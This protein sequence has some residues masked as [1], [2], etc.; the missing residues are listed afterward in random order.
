MP[1]R[2]AAHSSTSARAAPSLA[3]A[4]R[5]QRRAGGRADSPAR[6]GARAPARRRPARSC[7]CDRPHRVVLGMQRLDD[8]AARP[9][10]PPRRPPTGAGRRARRR[11]SRHAQQ[12]VEGDEADAAEA[13]RRQ[14]AQQRGRADDH[15]GVAASARD[16]E[17]REALPHRGLD[18]LRIPAERREPMA[19]ARRAAIGQGVGARAEPAAEARPV[20][21][22]RQRHAA[23]GAAQDGAALVAAQRGGPAGDDQGGARPARAMSSMARVSGSVSG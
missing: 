9:A 13:R 4:H 1:R 16:G 15:L 14:R 11:G 10:R 19:A 23:V 17:P 12:P 2:A 7:A 22:E 3:A 20:A 8:D 6:P 5:D 18:A 21:R